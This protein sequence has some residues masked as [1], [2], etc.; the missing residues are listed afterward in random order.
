MGL[1][2]GLGMGFDVG[3]G[4]GS[5]MELSMGFNVGFGMGLN[6]CWLILYKKDTQTHFKNIGHF[7][8]Q[9]GNQPGM[10]PVAAHGFNI[11]N[12][13]IGFRFS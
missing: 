3:F 4:T 7:Q 10:P 9:K 8:T 11:P 13:L 6:K 5:G 12:H 2:M 1:S